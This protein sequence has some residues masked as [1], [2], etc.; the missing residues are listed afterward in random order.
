M[1]IAYY[2][3]GVRVV[4]LSGL[5]G[6]ALGKNGVGMKQLG[7]YRFADSNTWAV[8]APSVSRDG[9]YLYGNDHRRG[10]DVY[11]WTPAA[12][13]ESV[14]AGKWLNAAQALDASREIAPAAPR[15]AASAFCAA[16]RAPEALRAIACPRPWTS[17]PPIASPSCSSA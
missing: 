3:G 17:R 1:T 16:E 2:N 15:S 7:C 5:V 9:F 12:A 11:K 6:V 13:A 10:F 4:D 8:K 14:S